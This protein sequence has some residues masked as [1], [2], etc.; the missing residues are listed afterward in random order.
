M[1]LAQAAVAT[2]FTSSGTGGLTGSSGLPSGPSG[3]P[4][5]QHVTSH[6]LR[7][8]RLL[9]DVIHSPKH[10]RLNS[11]QGF[12]PP[13]LNCNLVQVERWGQTAGP[14][15][16]RW[17]TCTQAG[18]QDNMPWQLRLQ[19]HRKLGGLSPSWEEARLA[20]RSDTMVAGCPDLHSCS[21]CWPAPSSIVTYLLLELLPLQ[22]LHVYRG[23]PG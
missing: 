3:A 20:S 18:C 10:P 14:T 8:T 21:R 7:N 9:L 2:P 13:P 12:A 15:Q 22:Q 19:V 17:T 23:P 6:R 4:A 11:R 1:T 5:V 16:I